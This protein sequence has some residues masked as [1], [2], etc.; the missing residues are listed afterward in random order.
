MFVMGYIMYTV[1]CRLRS[2]YTFVWLRKNLSSGSKNTKTSS[3]SSAAARR[4]GLL[5]FSRLLPCNIKAWLMA[6]EEAAL[7]YTGSET[8]IN[9]WWGQKKTL[10]TLLHTH[11]Y[12]HRRRGQE[13]T[14]R[15]AIKSHTGLIMGFH[16]GEWRCLYITEQE[17]ISSIFTVK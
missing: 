14:Q 3:P 2:A 4:W 15:A 1:T 9:T 12:T 17:D 10:M 7:D 8:H 16:R 11:M 5:W 6:L 13:I